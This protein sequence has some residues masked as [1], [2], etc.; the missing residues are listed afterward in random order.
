[1]S[2]VLDSLGIRVMEPYAPGNLDPV[3]DLVVVG[4]VIRRS[5]PEAIAVETAGIPSTSMPSAL[6]HYFAREKIR[7]VVAG[8][9]G[10][11]TV[12]SMLAWI[13]QYNGHDPSFMIGGLAGNFGTNHRLGNGDAFII[14]GDE[15]DTAYFDKSPKFLHYH[16]SIAILTSC[17]FDHADM[18]GSLDQI[19]AQF[20]TLTGMVPQA[21]TVIYYGDDD[22]V[23]RALGQPVA[24][25]EPYGMDEGNLWHINDVRDT[26]TGMQ[27]SVSYGHQQLCEGLIPV[28]GHHNA[29]N[30][31]AAIAAASHLKIAPQESMEALGTYAGVRRRQEFVGRGGGVMLV[32]DF[33]HHPTEVKATC[34]ALCA[35]FPNRRLVAVFEPRTNT[36]RRNTFQEE[37]AASFDGAAAVIVQRPGRVEDIAEN[38]RFDS[39]KLAHELDAQGKQAWAFSDADQIW[40]FLAHWLQDGDVVVTMSNGSFAGL[41]ARLL[42]TLQ[43]RDR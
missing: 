40:A 21:G 7:L 2:H 29:L 23:T 41:N 28:V 19:A 3:P 22:K 5:N 18:Y 38:E 17:E 10:K 11:T 9:H 30:A 15:Y 37:Y 12:S 16:P 20:Q 43:D 8:T 42:A 32:D 1:M 24:A 6:Y 4:N 33:A 14:E 25:V 27:F 39:D 34:K 13:L 26:G 36:S 35:R 31:L